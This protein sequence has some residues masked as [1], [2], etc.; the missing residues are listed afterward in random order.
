MSLR[1]LLHANHEVESGGGREELIVPEQ[2]SEYYLGN[3]T[4]ESYNS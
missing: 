2:S 3:Q 4:F 1:C